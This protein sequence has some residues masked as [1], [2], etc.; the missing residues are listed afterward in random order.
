MNPRVLII[1]T[2]DPRKS[3]RPA[4]ALRIAAGVG[5]WKK[6][7]ITVYLA[8]EAVQVLNET[9]DDLMEQEIY[10]KC[11]E[12]LAETGKPVYAAKNADR[13]RE[14][15]TTAVAVMEISDE[16]LAQ[17]AAEQTFVMRF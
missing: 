8:R 1:I 16:Q 9:A 12:I 17:L 5:V 2:G 11:W 15:E 3:A 4:E 10:A 7:D 6:A 13:L 14:T